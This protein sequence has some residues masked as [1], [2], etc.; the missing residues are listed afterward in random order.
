M[1]IQPTDP[2]SIKATPTRRTLYQ[3]VAVFGICPPVT[4]VVSVVAGAVVVVAG[5]L[6][7]VVVAGAVVVVVPAV[8]VVVPAVV[9]VVPAVVV[10]A[11]VV[12]VCAVTIAGAI[13]NTL[14]NTATAKTKDFVNIFFIFLPFFVFLYFFLF[15]SSSVLTPFPLFNITATFLLYPSLVILFADLANQA[16]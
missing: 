15:V 11:A 2:I 9:V 5:A 1:V 13:N 6:V 8:V 12:V 4:V 10:V 7:V 3:G 14:R 16:P